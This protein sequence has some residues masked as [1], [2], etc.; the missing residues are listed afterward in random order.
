MQLNLLTTC[1]R[2]CH[3]VL[4]TNLVLPSAQHEKLIHTDRESSEPVLDTQV[5]GSTTL[6]SLYTRV[7][8]VPVTHT[9]SLTR[10]CNRVV[11][12]YTV[13]FCSGFA[14]GFRNRLSGIDGGLVA[15]SGSQWRL[16][17]AKPV[18]TGVNLYS[19][20]ISSSID[21]WIPCVQAY[22]NISYP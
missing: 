3:L 9:F 13:A 12:V 2:P 15:V 19:V 5:L 6:H 17:K 11:R 1:I 21:S 14:L 22:M 4:G 8:T 16:A 20:C 18:L 7:S 10:L